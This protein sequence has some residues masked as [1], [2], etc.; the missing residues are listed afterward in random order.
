MNETSIVK[1]WPW[2]VS[3]SS[4][5]LVFKYIA[6]RVGILQLNMGASNLSMLE[7]LSQETE[8]RPWDVILYYCQTLVR[9]HLEYC[10]WFRPSMIGKSHYAAILANTIDKNAGRV[11]GSELSGEV[12]QANRSV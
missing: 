4:V 11:R 5:I 10:I 3:W 7:V 8:C 12:G 6:L 1:V 2:G 9:A